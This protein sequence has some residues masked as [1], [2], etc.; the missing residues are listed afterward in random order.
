MHRSGF[1][2][3]GHSTR[4]GVFAVVFAALAC[5]AALLAVTAS[6]S[7]PAPHRW[8]VQR[9]AVAP[10]GAQALGAPAA[11]AAQTGFVVLKPRDEASLKR[12]IAA[13]STPHSSAFHHYLA[14]GQFAGRFG[15]DAATVSAVKLALARDGLRVTS[16]ARD[17]MLIGFSGT[18][19]TVQSAFA[20]K[21]ER[22][23]TAAGVTGEQTT[24]A[25]TLPSTI[26]GAVSTVVGLDTLLRPHS[27]LVRAPASAYKGRAAAIKGHITTYPAGSP[28]P[29]ADASTDASLYGG[30]SDDQIANAYGAFGLYSSGDLGAGVSIGVYELEPFSQNDLTT[31]DECYF[32]TTTMGSV[33]VHPVDGGQAAGSG[34]GEAILDVEDVSAMAPQ[35]SIDVYEAPNSTAGALDNYA[36]MVNADTDKIITSS[37]GLCEQDEQLA[38]PGYQQAE[39]Y[40]FQQAAAQGQ[41]VLNATGDTGS[42]ACNEIRSVPPPTDQNPLSVGDPASQPYVMAVG[43]T[44]IQDADPTHY[45]ETVWNDG[46][47]W[48]SGNGGISESWAAPS[49]QQALPGFPT[50]SSGDYTQANNVE[51]SAAAKGISDQ[52]WS[53]GFCANNPAIGFAVGS[54]TLPAMPCRTTPDVSAQADEFT[55]AVTIYGSAFGGWTTIGGTSSATPIWAAMLALTDASGS[56]TS[57]GVSAATG[58]GFASPLLYA[59]ANNPTT[60]ADSF[61]D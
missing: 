3:R 53:P 33:N 38:V 22:Y 17:G 18:T 4:L 34:S 41:T 29:C 54:T 1:G 58:I 15:P 44:T 7:T 42:D 10:A 2:R 35:A 46:A 59:V 25:L 37:W 39:D 12:F 47:E 5:A 23:R 52:N 57:H 40:I 51:T 55:G 49:W 8:A 30:L 56:C 19:A 24:G 45:N 48:G 26:S 16:V 31:F 27:M 21:L 36:A 61:N 43:G 14:A 20:T 13:A 28:Q 11:D 32:P 60:Y 9:A 6:G 50:P